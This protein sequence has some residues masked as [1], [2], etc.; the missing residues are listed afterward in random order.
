SRLPQG[1]K[2]SISD[3]R[4]PLSHRIDVDRRPS[5]TLHQQ[6]TYRLL[7]RRYQVVL[8]LRRQNWVTQ[9]GQVTTPIQSGSPAQWDSDGFAAA[10]WRVVV[11][12]GCAHKE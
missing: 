3:W 1:A 8:A 12:L 7:M 9:M 4:L 2:G 11:V 10:F 6:I 5:A